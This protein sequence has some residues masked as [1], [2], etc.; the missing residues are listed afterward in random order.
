MRSALLVPCVAAALAIS[1]PASAD[2]TPIDYYRTRSVSLTL[3][4]D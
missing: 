1:A 2:Q 4:L 3:G